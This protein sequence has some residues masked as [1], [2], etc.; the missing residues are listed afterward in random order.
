MSVVARFLL[1]KATE[2]V[3][4]CIKNHWRETWAAVTAGM[5]ATDHGS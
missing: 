2:T 4:I 1:Q 3:E 5:K